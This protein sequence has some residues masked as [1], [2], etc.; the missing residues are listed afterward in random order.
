[1]LKRFRQFSPARSA[2]WR[3]FLAALALFSLPLPTIAAFDANNLLADNDL[4]DGESMSRAGIQN[5]LS[6]KGSALASLRLSTLNSEKLAA[7]IIY[8]AGKYWGI[9]QKYLLVRLQVEQGLVLSKN[10]TVRQLEYAAGYGCPDSSSCDPKYKGF[11][12]QVNW[13]ARALRGDKYLG[14]IEKN[15]RTISGWGPGITKQTL[16]GIMVTPSNAATAVLY[17][18]TPWVGKY[19]GGDQRYGGSSLIWKKFNDWFFRRFP[20]GSLVRESETHAY[21]RIEF[22]RKRLFRSLTVLQSTQ[23]PGKALSATAAELAA[24]ENG[25]A[26]VFANYSLVRSPRGTVFLIVDGA[27]RGI[28]SREVFRT[29]GFNPEEVQNTSWDDLNTYPDGTPID[30]SSAYPA[31]ALLRSAESGGISYVEN[32]VRHALYSAEIFKARFKGRPLITVAQNELEQYP[33]GDPVL[34]PEGE[35]VTGPGDRSIYFISDGHRRPIA[36][37][38]AFDRLGFS[39]RNIITTNTRALEIH[40][41]GDPLDF[42]ETPD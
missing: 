20:D 3:V 12:N 8:D 17:T 40:P 13:A 23:D 25:P 19:G 37:R 9:S 18:Y 22:G 5:F 38:D 10:P 32:G 36:S 6:K 28:A 33:A 34:F 27:K 4:M 39:W 21:Y 29:L 11:F 14:G 15:G 41:I 30:L 35:L 26:I 24:Y 16:D 2:G 1:M 7:D 31:G 42:V